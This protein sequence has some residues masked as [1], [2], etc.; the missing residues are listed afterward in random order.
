MDIAYSTTA[1]NSREGV[2]IDKTYA[3]D[4]KHIDVAKKHN[5]KQQ[6]G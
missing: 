5:M 2:L 4:E 6:H 1:W 3:F